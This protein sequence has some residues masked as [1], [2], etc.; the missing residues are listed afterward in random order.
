MGLGF[1]P[2]REFPGFFV[3]IGPSFSFWWSLGTLSLLAPSKLP[4][5]IKLE[6]RFTAVWK[7][8]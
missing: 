6:S 3:A 8:D 7:D 5:D 1:V 4:D 2:C